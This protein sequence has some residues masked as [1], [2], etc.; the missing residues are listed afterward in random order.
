MGIPEKRKALCHVCAVI[1]VFFLFFPGGKIHPVSIP[2]AI[3]GFTSTYGAWIDN[4]LENNPLKDLFEQED[5]ERYFKYQ[6]MVITGELLAEEE[7]FKESQAYLR[8]A[9]FQLQDI[10]HELRN[11]YDWKKEHYSKEEIATWPPKAAEAYYTFQVQKI[12]FLLQEEYYYTLKGDFTGPIQKNI[13]E[14]IQIYN[15]LPSQSDTFHRISQTWLLKYLLMAKASLDISKQNPVSLPVAEHLSLQKS[16]AAILNDY[17]LHKL[18][19]R[20]IIILATQGYSKQALKLARKLQNYNP[21]TLPLSLYTKILIQNGLFPEAEKIIRN[22]ISKLNLKQKSSWELYVRYKNRVLRLLLIS[23][24]YRQALKEIQEL[25]KQLKTFQNESYLAADINEYIENRVFSLQLMQVALLKHLNKNLQITPHL[26]EIKTGPGNEK[27]LLRIYNAMLFGE[28]AQFD[29]TAPELQE[30]TGL[31]P[32][33][34]RS[35]RERKIKT[36]GRLLKQIEKTSQAPGLKDHYIHICRLDLALLQIQKGIKINER[37]LVTLYNRALQSIMIFSPLA[38]YLETGILIDVDLQSRAKTLLQ[39]YR[40]NLSLKT[41]LD[42]IAPLPVVLNWE[43]TIHLPPVYYNSPEGRIRYLYFAHWLSKADTVRPEYKLTALVENAPP[44]CRI[45]SI[46]WR[47]YPFENSVYSLVWTGQSKTRILHESIKE[48]S[49]LF[50]TTQKFYEALKQNTKDQN[51]KTHLLEVQ[52]VFSKE[53]GFIR[54]FFKELGIAK[55]E[56]H[57][58]LSGYLHSLPVEAMSLPEPGKKETP[59][60]IAYSL[61]RKLPSDAFFEYIACPMAQCT[62]L[63]KKNREPPP[64]KAA[65]KNHFFLGIARH[66]TPN[67]FQLN[68]NEADEII[69]IENLFTEK[70]LLSASPN[71]SSQMLSSAKARENLILHIAGGWNFTGNNPRLV[72][73]NPAYKIQI[74]TFKNSPQIP[75]SVFSRQQMISP[76]PGDFTLWDYILTTFH[77]KETRYL[78]S[79]MAIIPKEFRQAFFYDFYYKS[80]HK[81]MEW[82]EALHSARKRTSKRFAEMPWPWLLVLYEK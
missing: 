61:I 65:L 60:A 80:E 5:F 44:A 64:K 37:R 77:Y 27:K 9:R 54:T 21:E 71:I 69:E 13:V 25:Q 76:A 43:K 14:A 41:R 1:L 55:Q 36:A 26:E 16:D 78:I 35:I 10:F 8:R 3:S 6:S 34:I 24:R 79:S 7:N 62:P 47:L 49:K 20:K 73:S 19:K 30:E 11:Q 48:S 4:L 70:E 29:T 23:G 2:Q 66:N 17:W 31:Y 38:H 40:Q 74:A 12:Y 57:L 51:W 28:K 75:Y 53:I 68:P 59:L 67:L 15:S 39:H 72:I 32:L 81:Y 42:I 22:K 33:F 52:K 50:L 45:N 82:P 46:C 56:I 18:Q 58:F 63:D